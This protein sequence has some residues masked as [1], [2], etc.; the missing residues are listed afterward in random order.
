MGRRVR[1]ECMFCHNAYPD[2]PAGSDVYGARPAYPSELPQGIGC[3]RC[4]G[5]GSGHVGQALS[6]PL[7]KLF[8]PR[9]SIRHG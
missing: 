6:G 2:V 5:P 4:Y 8:A 3:Q 9:S 7:W 1:R